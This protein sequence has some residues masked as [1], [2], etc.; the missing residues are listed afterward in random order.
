MFLI[1]FPLILFFGV[2]NL[3]RIIVQ[4]TKLTLVLLVEERIGLFRSFSP[5]R[6]L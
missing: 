5:E 4:S 6:D 1:N 2:E 3:L